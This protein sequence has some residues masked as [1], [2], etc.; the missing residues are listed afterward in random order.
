MV[1]ALEC[2]LRRRPDIF[3]DSSGYAFTFPIVKLFGSKI[4]SYV[5]YP[6]ISTV[7][8]ILMPSLMD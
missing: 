7:K 4:I 3:I 6:T 1:V 2:M 5:H 8:A